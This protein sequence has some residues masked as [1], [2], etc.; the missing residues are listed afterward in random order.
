MGGKQKKYNKKE[1]TS[2]FAGIIPIIEPKLVIVV[3]IDEPKTKPNEFFGGHISAPVFRKVAADSLRILN[4]S[5]DK[6]MDYQKQV[7]TMFENLDNYTLKTPEV[8]Y[9]F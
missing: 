3:V 1:H 6:K 2:L 9:V 7:S 5:P 4:I 8:P